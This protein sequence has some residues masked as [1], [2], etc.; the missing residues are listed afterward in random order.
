MTIFL[1]TERGCVLVLS[2]E[3]ANEKDGRRDFYRLAADLVDQLRLADVCVRSGDTC[4]S[5]PEIAIVSNAMTLRMLREA[6]EGHLN[7]SNIASA[8]KDDY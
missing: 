7:R 8:W 3:S 1:D 4:T 2:Y 6:V 5:G